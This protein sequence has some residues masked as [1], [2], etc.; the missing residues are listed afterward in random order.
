VDRLFH[1]APPVR[2]I[3][4]VALLL[5]AATATAAGC[6]ELGAD[7]KGP[8]LTPPEPLARAAIEHYPAGS[9]ERVVALWYAALQRGDAASAARYY[10]TGAA[11]PRRRLRRLLAEATPFF[12]RVALGPL[13]DVARFGTSATV[14]AGLRVRW[15]T[16]NGRAQEVRRPQAFTLVRERRAWRL[17][18]TYFLSF[19]A[20][21][22]A[23][24]PSRF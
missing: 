21:F 3:G 2:R 19:A 20:G 5:L 17:A 18:D 7:W 10:S 9:P 11:P 15:E 13:T 12:D 22:R 1:P 6:G 23:T 24:R 14:Y 16:P 8:R 4:A